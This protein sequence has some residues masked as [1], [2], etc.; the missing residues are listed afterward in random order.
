LPEA[1]GPTV[2]G[3]SL[4]LMSTTVKPHVSSMLPLR[5]S[6]QGTPYLVC[7]GARGAGGAGGG[8]G[9]G[10]D[11]EARIV[12]VV[13]LVVVAEVTRLARSQSSL[14]QTPDTP[15]KLQAVPCSMPS[16]VVL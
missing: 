11:P 10:G 4:V 1:R 15:L 6:A 8:G 9:G 7:N 3:S 14:L 12:V 5:A 16:N 2:L 13:A